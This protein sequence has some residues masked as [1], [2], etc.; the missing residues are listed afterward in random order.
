MAIDVKDAQTKQQNNGQQ[1]GVD[2][3][4]RRRLC[5]AFYRATEFMSTACPIT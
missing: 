5:G 2:E 3:I 4:L 1:H